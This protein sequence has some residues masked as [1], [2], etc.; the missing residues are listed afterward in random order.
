[1]KMQKEIFHQSRRFKVIFCIVLINIY[2]GIH[3]A[4][5]IKHVFTLRTIKEQSNFSL[6]ADFIKEC[7]ESFGTDVFVE[8]GTYYGN[9]TYNAL[10]YFKSLHTIELASGLYKKVIERFK[11]EK[12]IFAYLG[13]AAEI[14]PKI[15]PS[16][17]GKILFWLDGHYSG[18]ETTQ[19]ESSSSIV[20][21]IKAIQNSHIKNATILIDDMRF[22]KPFNQPFRGYPSIN[23]V[24]KELL[25][26]NQN[27]RIAIY[28]EVAMIY[29]PNDNFTFSP[30]INAC[31]ISRMAQDDNEEDIRQAIEAEKIIANAAGEEKEAIKSLYNS[32]TINNGGYGLYYALW[33]GLILEKEK[34][35]DRAKKEFQDVLKK[36]PNNKRA[37]YYLNRLIKK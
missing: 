21:E 18:G 33:Y 25:K 23:Q 4:N 9:T 36:S 16:I 27:Y 28:G 2:L 34:Q 37:L 26:A 10:P 11:H 19:G 17:N 20:G 1:M 6:Q 13:D 14:L 32:F 12:K 22:F 5:Q 3:P 29:L 24:Y 31:T 8:T 30:L 7:G 35:Y 15:L